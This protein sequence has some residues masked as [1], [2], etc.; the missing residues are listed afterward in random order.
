M[1]IFSVFR[2]P[3][4]PRPADTAKERLQILLAHERADAMSPDYLPTLQMELLKV[5]EKYVDVQ[6]DKVEVKLE[7]G[8]DMS[9]LEVNIELPGASTLR[10]KIAR[11]KAAAVE[12]KSAG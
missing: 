4:K 7:R 11:G 12:Q 3:S 8:K 9:V 1:S 6:D 10:E 2:T 5:I